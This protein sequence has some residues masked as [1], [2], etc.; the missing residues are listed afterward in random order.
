MKPKDRARVKRLESLQPLAGSGGGGS[1][2]LVGQAFGPSGATQVQRI[3]LGPVR[4]IDPSNSTGFASDLNSGANATNIPLGSGPI[5]TTAHL[6]SLLF[7]RFLTSSPTITYLSDDP[8]PTGL[9]YSTLDLNGFNISFQGTPVTLHTGGT[10]NVGTVAINP[11]GNQRQLV[12]TSDLAT[13]APFIFTGLGGASP[14][15]TRIINS[16][17]NDGAWIVSGVAT[18]SVTRPVTPSGDAGALTIGNPYTIKRGSTLTLATASGFLSTPGLV[19]G[20]VTFSDFAFTPASYGNSVSAT[21]YIRC[22]FSSNATVGGNYSDCAMGVGF[23]ELGYTSPTDVEIIAGLLVTTSDDIWTAPFVMTNDVYVTGVG[24]MVAEVIGYANV[25]LSVPTFPGGGAI[26]LQDN[27]VALHSAGGALSI[28]K[29]IH[30]GNK[31]PSIGFESDGLIWGNGNGGPGV[32]VGPGASL[33]VSAIIPPT[34]TGAGG[35][36]AFIAPNTPTLT[37]VARAWNDAVGAYTEAGGVA[38]RTT[39]WAHFVAAIGAGGFAFEA[40][41]PATDASIVGINT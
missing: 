38:T 21:Q 33:G 8:S 9:D 22:S 31:L 29:T 26:Q 5:L 10:F 35:D 34:V 37:T 14:N 41:N 19:A 28:L 1:V 24:F 36:F 3:A 2:T 15:P 39:T 11:A 4:F 27:V 13:F 20:F 40:H 7:Y 23:I 18:A 16:I 32:V 12:H 30:L 25:F 17:T 6:N